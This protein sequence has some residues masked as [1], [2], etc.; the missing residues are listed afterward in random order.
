MWE[1]E[2]WRIS[3][4]VFVGLSR[5]HRDVSTLRAALNLNPVSGTVR[6]VVVDVFDHLNLIMLE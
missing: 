2:V 6:W 4:I 5:A 1:C 3:N